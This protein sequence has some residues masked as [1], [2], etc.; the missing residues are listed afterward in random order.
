MRVLLVDDDSQNR[1]R[2]R[3]ALQS[4]RHETVEAADG[5]EALE[6]LHAQDVDAVVSDVLMPRMD[7]YRLCREIR[8]SQ[9]HSRLPLIVHSSTFTSDA[10]EHAALSA[11]ADRFIRRPASAD[12]I[13]QALSETVGSFPRP[14]PSLPPPEIARLREYNEDLVRRLEEKTG[15]LEVS[16]RRTR[17]LVDLAPIGIFRSTPDGRFASANAALARLLG[18]EGPADLLGLDIRKDLYF[19]ESDRDRWIDEIGHG[20]AI[21]TEMRVKRRNGSPIWVALDARVIAGDDGET[22]Y[23]EGF[24]RDADERRRVEDEMRASEA[25]Y[26]ILF[27]SNPQPMWVFDEKTFA[28]LAVNEAACSHYGYGREEFLRMTLR[29]IRPREDVPAFLDF[30][31]SRGEDGR[32]SGVWRH[33]KKDGS[34]IEVLVSSHALVFD[35]RYAQLVLA[36]DVTER[37]QLE[38][39]MRHAQKMEAVDRLAGG[40]ARDFNDLLA[41]IL[42]Y[43]HLLATRFRDDEP[44]RQDVDEIR[45]AGGRAASLTRQLLAFCRE[46]TLHPQVFDLRDVVRGMEPILHRLVGEDIELTTDLAVTP[47]TVR[48]DPGQIEQVLVSLVVNARDA[49]P[50]GGALR[51][52]TASPG[53]GEGVP[54]APPGPVAVLSV[55]DSGAGMDSRVVEHLFEPFFTTK[56]PGR[57]SG[58]GLATSYGI[59]RQSGGSLLVRSEPGDGSTFQVCLPRVDVPATGAP[60]TAGRHALPRGSETVLIVED[61]EPVVR[62]VRAILESHGY[63]LLA[64]PTA[65]AALE[66]ARTH[67]GP[68][69]LLVTDLVTPGMRGPVLAR[70][71]WELR[72]DVKALFTSGYTDAAVVSHGLLDEERSFLQKPFTPTAL[73]RKVRE[74]LDLRPGGH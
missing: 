47:A 53:P 33:R 37:R 21:A 29:D 27:E 13:V 67:Q 10:D 28:F 59:I 55:I 65:D 74:V 58:L 2:M 30:L 16:E 69:D 43:T 56:E 25:R 49:M 41:A 54:G 45:K 60:L 12:V 6:T 52:E 57:G 14:V 18:Y 31:A 15:E 26:R 46:Q 73:L 24:V 50:E 68:I 61:D 71:L 64:A 1:K 17:E 34:Q 63:R 42:A 72:P 9:K 39:E 23:F 19:E 7:G 22:A 44:G 48:A 62:L 38:L 36:Q 35:G 8:R 5:I 4:A 70:R 51:I 66:I 11:G 3:A 20:G 32:E 40:V